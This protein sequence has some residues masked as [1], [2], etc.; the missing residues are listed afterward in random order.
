VRCSRDG[1]F[2]ACEGQRSAQTGNREL[3]RFRCAGDPLKCEVTR[4]A[5]AWKAAVAASAGG[6]QRLS[7][8]AAPAGPAPEFHAI[9]SPDTA[10]RSRPARSAGVVSMRPIG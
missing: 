10:A 4:G 6:S 5:A 8:H 3:L 9:P 1:D 7:C 2:L